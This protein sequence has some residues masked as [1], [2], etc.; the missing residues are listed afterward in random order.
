[1]NY[2]SYTSDEICNKL[3]DNLKD[4][5]GVFDFCENLKGINERF[6][7]LSLY[8][9]LRNDPCTAVK[10]W[11]Y[12][13]LFNLPYKGKN[14]NDFNN[15]ILKI[16]EIINED[17]K[18]KKCNLFNFPY[19]KEDFEKM[20]NLYDYATNYDTIKRHIEDSTYI[21]TQ[22]MYDYIIK[23]DELYMNEKNKCKTQTAEKKDY[24]SVFEY[25][26]DAYINERLPRLY[27][28]VKSLETI[29]KAQEPYISQEEEL[30]SGNLE[31][32]R[33]VPFANIIVS[34]IFPLVGILFIF[35]ILFKFTSFKSW[36]KTLLLKKK[37]I[38]YSE[39]EQY[40]EGYLNKSYRTGGHR[41]RY[42]PL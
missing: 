31:Q 37:I 20:K 10:F 34:V 24:C 40:I 17:D 6:D 11:M 35:F 1:N 4:Y 42:H 21:C 3:G 19:L 16:K 36:L 29:V 2:K 15:I 41:M 39:D 18:I 13:R 28:K 27:C 9:E 33:S 14:G 7:N 32:K 12:S 22:N 8:G 5:S 26:K 38:Q 30:S 25:I 23:N